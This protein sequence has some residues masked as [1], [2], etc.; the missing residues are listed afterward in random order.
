MHSGIRTE[1]TLYTIGTQSRT[2]DSLLMAL[3]FDPATVVQKTEDAYNHLVLLRLEQEHP[4]SFFISTVWEGETGS[5]WNDKEVK[6][7]LMNTAQRLTEP[8]RVSFR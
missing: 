7:F 3:T 8:M 6:S 4:V 2:N 1:A 5:M